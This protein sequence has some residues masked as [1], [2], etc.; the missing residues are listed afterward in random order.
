MSKNKITTKLSEILQKM[1][2]KRK[3]SK[4]NPSTLVKDSRMKSHMHNGG[5][6]MKFKSVS[7]I[8]II[9]ATT[10]MLTQAC[11]GGGGGGGGGGATT[12]PTI[13]HLFYVDC[14]DS[15]C[16]ED[17]LFEY[18]PELGTH[19]RV[20][21]TTTAAIGYY[22]STI[23]GTIAVNGKLYYN[24][25]HP[26]RPASELY[27]YDPLAPKQAGVNPKPVY[28]GTGGADVAIQNP[29][30]FFAVGDIIYFSASSTT[31]PVNEL[32]I[33]DTT[34]PGSST[35]PQ[36]IDVHVGAMIG[37]NPEYFASYN[38]KIY[39]RAYTVSTGYELWVYDPAQPLSYLV[40]PAPLEIQQGSATS[41]VGYLTVHNNKLYFYCE[42]NSG[43]GSE[44]CVYDDSIAYG[45]N[46][47]N[48]SM[49]ADIDSGASNSYPYNFASVGGKLVF[50][51]TTVAAGHELYVYDDSQAVSINNPQM[52]SIN[53][54][55]N[56]Y[57]SNGFAVVGN[58]YFFAGN[59][60]ANGSELYSY[61]VTQAVSG[62][63]PQLLSLVSGSGRA[64]PD[65]ITPCLDGSV[66][67]MALDP[68]ATPSDSAYLFALPASST[69]VSFA[70]TATSFPS[71]GLDY[72]EPSSFAT[73]TWTVE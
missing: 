23:K 49:V 24:G 60:G 34:Q 65:Y 39:F 35:N 47:V 22:S 62:S 38:N 54:S 4:I 52:I 71:V 9:L 73:I 48:P 32:Y 26:A 16:N 25:R 58:K 37:S 70:N 33:F 43:V 46:G 40:N 29:Y 55:G 63:N 42:V 44:L 20:D 7:S 11:S 8:F 2:F 61:D 68:S 28:E 14:E 15:A 21:S 51:A 69:S 19:T 72:G 67:F 41:D 18:A 57:E 59:D 5:I 6:T 31:S 56:G 27:V 12:V 66:C 36:V 50:T 45:A 53:S 3:Q 1:S 13:S 10:M 64:R 30:A 17:A